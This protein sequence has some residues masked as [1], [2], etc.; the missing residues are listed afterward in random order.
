LTILEDKLAQAIK[1]KIRKLTVEKPEITS[2]SI[3]LLQKNQFHKAYVLK[4]EHALGKTLTVED[5]REDKTLRAIVINNIIKLESAFF[6]DVF[7][8]Y[9]PRILALKG[10]I[11]RL[12]I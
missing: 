5:Y 10:E 3:E 6:E 12:S 4:K 8:H 2:Q 1:D 11:E 9:N 7:N